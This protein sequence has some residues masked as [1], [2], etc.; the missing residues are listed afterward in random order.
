VPIAEQFRKIIVP[1]TSGIKTDKD[2]P[3]YTV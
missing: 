3:V 2:S 1:S